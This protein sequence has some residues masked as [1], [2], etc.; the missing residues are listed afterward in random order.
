[1]GFENKI[2]E[3]EAEEFITRLL[4]IVC[5]CIFLHYCLTIL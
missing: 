1:M 2:Y 4:V 5:I 3:L